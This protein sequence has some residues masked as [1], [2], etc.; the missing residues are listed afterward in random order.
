MVTTTHPASR[1]SP[2]GITD[3]TKEPGRLPYLSIQALSPADVLLGLD[4][5]QIAKAIKELNEQLAVWGAIRGS[6]DMYKAP[7]G[8][9]AES[10][11]LR[12]VVIYVFEKA[13]WC[14]EHHPASAGEVD[15]RPTA[16]C[17]YFREGI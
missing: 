13:G 10:E 1:P 6:K 11:N 15:G 2:S 7:R 8:V 3:T 9:W 12:K 4:P 16:E 14:V 5:V 17:L